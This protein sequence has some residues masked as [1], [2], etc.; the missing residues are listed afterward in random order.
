MADTKAQIEAET[1]IRETYL[2]K[3]Y[4]PAFRQ[5]NLDLRSGG[6]FKFDAVSDDNEIVAVISTSAGFTST[7]KRGAA[8]LMKI[9]SDAFWFLMLER[10]PR[11]KLMI[12]T[13]QS[14][15]DIVNDEKKK[16]RFPS[17]FEILKVDLPRTLA[18]KITR[19]QKLAAEEVTPRRQAK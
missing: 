3:R 7:G 9:R 1:W 5:K 18:T 2:P 4:G 14:M 6:Q 19:A 15:I 12:F 13:D 17:E 11:Q 16:G 8:K 10:Q